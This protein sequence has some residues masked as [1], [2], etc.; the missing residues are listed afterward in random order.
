[1]FERKPSVLITMFDITEQKLAEEVLS[2][3]RA[4]A[5]VYIDLMSHDINN[6][7]LVAMGN[8]ELLL[9][10]WQADKKVEDEDLRLIRSSYLTLQ[11]IQSSSVT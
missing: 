6:M 4:Q 8:L 5:E 2:R 1:M 9:D 11:S 3:A 7:N 10:K